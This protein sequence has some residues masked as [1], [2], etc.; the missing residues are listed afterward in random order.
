MVRVDTKLGN[1][2]HSIWGGQPNVWGEVSFYIKVSS[3]LRLTDTL[4]VMAENRYGY[5]VYVDDLRVEKA[6][7]K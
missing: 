2:K 3:H 7:F 1:P 5:P 6:V 4:S